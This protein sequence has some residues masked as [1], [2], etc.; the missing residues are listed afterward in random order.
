M[1]RLFRGPYRGEKKQGRVTHWIIP[2]KGK[3]PFL[4]VVRELFFETTRINSEQWEKKA[5]L[6]GKRHLIPKFLGFFRG[7]VGRLFV[8]RRSG[9]NCFEKQTP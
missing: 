1:A 3:K 2:Y 5:G 4:R 7:L 6:R 8:F 9:R